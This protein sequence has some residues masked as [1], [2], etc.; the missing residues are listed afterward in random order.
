MVPTLS[1]LAGSLSSPVLPPVPRGAAEGGVLSSC[2]LSLKAPFSLPPRLFLLPS[3]HLPPW[4]HQLVCW[5]LGLGVGGVSCGQTAE[6][7]SFMGQSI[8]VLGLALG[9]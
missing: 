7:T 8:S 6:L 5:R 9:R 4:L 2:P 1:H 3:L